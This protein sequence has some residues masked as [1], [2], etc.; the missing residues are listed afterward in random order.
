[1]RSPSCTA[2]TRCLF[3]PVCRDRE[4]ACTACLYVSEISCAR[5]NS[6]LSRKVLFGGQAS[7]VLAAAGSF[8]G[9][10]WT[11]FWAP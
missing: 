5:F 6:G 9:R 3:D 8:G 7:L 1:M 2:E 4:T 11:G 10:A